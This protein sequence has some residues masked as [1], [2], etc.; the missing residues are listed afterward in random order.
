MTFYAHITG[1]GKYVPEKV[2]TNNDIAQFL[3]TSDEWI[4]TRTGISE[5]RFAAAEE[6]TASMAIAA[7]RLALAADTGQTGREALPA[8]DEWP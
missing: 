8:S 6:S 1:W 2:V 7:A 5:R 4:K 3:D